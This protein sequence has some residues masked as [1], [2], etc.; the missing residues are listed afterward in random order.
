MA[1]VNKTLF[2]RDSLG[3]KQ[4]LELNTYKD[5]AVFQSQTRELRSGE[6]MK[7]TRNHY[8]NGKKQI[9]GQHFEV[10]GFDKRG[11]TQ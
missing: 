5:R 8:Q 4:S 6:Q 3:N 2:L 1:I 10:L 11:Q 9:N 7:F